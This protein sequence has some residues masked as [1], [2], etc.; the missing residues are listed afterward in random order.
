MV[1]EYYT[2]YLIITRLPC[3]ICIMSLLQF[4][5]KYCVA[6]VVVSLISFDSLVENDTISLL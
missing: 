6:L 3:V 1:I 4:P 2:C 5:L